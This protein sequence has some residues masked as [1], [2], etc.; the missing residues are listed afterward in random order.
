MPACRPRRGR[1]RPR[2]PSA[3]GAPG[4]AG[5]GSRAVAVQD[6]ADAIGGG[7]LRVVVAAGSAGIDD[8]TLAEPAQG[9]VGQRGD[10][11]LG[12]A[13]DTPEAA[14]D[15]VARAGTAGVGG[16]AAAGAG[17]AAGGP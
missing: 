16:G 10:L 2:R 13:V 12:V 6:L 1:P 8:L 17:Q 15:L 7:L 3:R 5:P 9:L 14:A 11:V 4:P